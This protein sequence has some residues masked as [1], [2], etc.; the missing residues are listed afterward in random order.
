MLAQWIDG[1][2]SLECGDISGTSHDPIRLG[3][4]VSRG[5]L[6]NS[7]SVGA[8]LDGRFHVEP[9]QRRLLSSNDDVYVVAAAEAVIGY[10][11]EGVGIRR[12]VNAHDVGLLVYDVVDEARVLVGEAVVVLAP[13]V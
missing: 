6:P 7:D 1:R 12:Q 13:N 4:L 10:G 3:P 5:P 8:M 2:E 11:K 9:L